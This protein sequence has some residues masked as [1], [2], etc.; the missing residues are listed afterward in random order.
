MRIGI[1]GPNR[2]PQLKQEE[3]EIRKNNLR[4]VARIL[5]KT[6]QQ[7]RSFTRLVVRLLWPRYMH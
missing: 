3:L 6:F 4:E 2:C 5:A 1:I 7:Q